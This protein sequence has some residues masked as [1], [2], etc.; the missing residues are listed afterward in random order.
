MFNCDDVIQLLTDYVDGELEPGDQAL[1][2]RHFKGCPA[3][4]NFLKSFKITIELTGEYRCEDIPESVSHK[5][6][7]FL[8]QRIREIDSGQSS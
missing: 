7:D 1:L 8:D 6:H 4:D 2:D 5:L 3:C